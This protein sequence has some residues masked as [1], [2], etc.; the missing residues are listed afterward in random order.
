M[1][2]GP[3][4]GCLD[5]KIDDFRSRNR[6]DVKTKQSHLQTFPWSLNSASPKMGNHR[7]SGAGREGILGSIFVWLLTAKKAQTP[8][9]PR[10]GEG[11]S[12]L[13]W[14]KQ[15]KNRPRDPSRPAP[16]AMIPNFKG[17]TIERPGAKRLGRSGNGIVGY[18]KS[19]GLLTR[20]RRFQ[21]SK[22]PCAG[23]KPIQS[24]RARSTSSL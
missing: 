18:A 8:A 14:K 19:A 24:G 16:E 7:A 13:S 20:N 1:G 6:P 22:R 4:Q 21:V 15:H 23:P 10:R 5:H 11:L 12:P 3:L 2:F 9:A 17:S